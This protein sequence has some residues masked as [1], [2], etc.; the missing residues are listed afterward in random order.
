MGATSYIDRAL[1]D[2]YRPQLAR[3]RR[4]IEQLEKYCNGA[5]GWSRNPQ[6]ASST[7]IGFS[8]VTAGTIG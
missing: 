6:I 1:T 2:P 7:N 5:M 8:I 3:Y 4:G